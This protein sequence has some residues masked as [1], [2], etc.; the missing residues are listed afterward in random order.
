MRSTKRRFGLT[1]SLALLLSACGGASAPSTP[2]SP[3]GA[4]P[5][6]APA[7]KPAAPSSAAASKP[8]A[9]A[10]ASPAASKPAASRPAA[11]AGASAAGDTIRIGL[12]E[13]LTGPSASIGK[14]NQDG[15]NL[16][17][18]SVNGAMAGKKVEAIVADDQNQA[19]T[20]LTKAKELVDRMAASPEAQAAGLLAMRRAI[21]A[22]TAAADAMYRLALASG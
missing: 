1:L 18:K 10:A 21:A 6:S 3:S 22:R 2:A 20:G 14:D 8:A 19:D 4:P 12:L 7:S 17:L 9:S 11:S 5:A 13:P 15:F 16:Y